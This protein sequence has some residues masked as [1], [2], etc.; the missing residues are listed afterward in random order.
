[1]PFPHSHD[2]TEATAP[3]KAGALM[4][5]TG[6]TESA[7]IAASQLSSQF[8]AKA[9]VKATGSTVTISSAQGIKESDWVGAT[10]TLPTITAVPQITKMGI[11]MK[12]PED[13]EWEALH[14]SAAA[15]TSVLNKGL[16]EAGKT[17]QALAVTT[18]AHAYSVSLPAMQLVDG[19]TFALGEPTA[20]KPKKATSATLTFGAPVVAGTN[21]GA[22]VGFV[23]DCGDDCG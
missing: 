14:D 21:S 8:G 3:M 9:T 2:P 22:A 7:A 13:G 10:L 12:K 11:S 19:V 5:A 17:A 6:P 1:M 23:G 16:R 20:G 18:G 15:A 4:K